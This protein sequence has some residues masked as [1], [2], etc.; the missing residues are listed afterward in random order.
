MASIVLISI[1]YGTLKQGINA[2][3]I[4]ICI[5][6]LLDPNLAISWGF[7]LSVFATFG[8]LLLTEPI[9]NYLI[10]NFPWLNQNLLI[11]ISVALAAQFSTMGLVA[12]FTGLISLW[13]VFAN[14]LVLIRCCP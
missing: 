8:L 9:L 13:S 10:R 3:L 12:G 11:I 4:T 2:L 1:L 7:I 6:L 14:T 5:A